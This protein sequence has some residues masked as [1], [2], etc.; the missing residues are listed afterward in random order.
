MVSQHE[1]DTIVKGIDLSWMTWGKMSGEKLV[2]GDISY[3]KSENGKGFE[4]IFSIRIENNP[5]LR[6]QQMISHIKAGIMPDSMLITPN[7]KPV[8]LAQILSHKGFVINDNDP[9]MMMYLDAYKEEVA[10][11]PGFIV[12]NVTE[13]TQLA[14]WLNIVNEALFGCELV[15]LAQFYEI[16]ALDN[17]NFYLGRM[18]G[19]SVTACMTITEDDT[20]VLEMVATLS[21]YRRKGFASIIINNALIDLRQKG[22]KTISLRAEAD[23]VG[24]Y[25]RLGFKEGFQ[26]VVA[27]YEWK[28]KHATIIIE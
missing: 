26:R 15:T 3:L 22:I 28:A 9:C 17:T 5:E 13:Q 27:S 6:I 24:V 12:Y 10:V 16:L 8:G 23:G 20:S 1:I 18:D 2:V 4:R 7:T 19:K 25:K 14:E 11:Y 21:G